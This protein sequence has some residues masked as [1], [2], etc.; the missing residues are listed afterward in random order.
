VT[1]WTIDPR[2][3]GFAGFDAADLVGGSPEENARLIVDVLE[4]RGGPAATAAVILNAAGALYVAPGSRSFRDCVA[5]A[6]SAIGS[7]AGSAA[8]DRMRRAYGQ[9]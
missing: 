1:E 2:D 6:S 8:L 7:G 3:Y 5:T 4:G 9:R